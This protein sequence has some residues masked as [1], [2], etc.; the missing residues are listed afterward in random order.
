MP[1]GKKVGYQKVS[2]ERSAFFRLK[3]SGISPEKVADIMALHNQMDKEEIDIINK[4]REEQGKLPNKLWFD[5]QKM[6]KK[7]RKTGLWTA[8]Y[9]DSLMLFYSYNE[10]FMKL[11]K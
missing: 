6:I 9:V 7:A 11:K 1:G 10:M 3:T 4:K 2:L 8:D 5:K